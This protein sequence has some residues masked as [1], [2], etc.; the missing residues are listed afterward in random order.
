MKV[1]FRLRRLP[2][3]APA[4]GLLLESADAARLLDLCARLG[5]LWP[6]VY[7]V[8]G[9]F[10]VALAMPTKRR[11]PGVIRLRRLAANLYVPVD[12]ALVPAL[13]R[14]EAEGLVRER[15]LVFLPGA[16]VL[17]FDAHRPVAL[18]SLLSAGTPRRRVWQP[19]PSPRARADRLVDI[20][21]VRADEPDPEQA[22]ESE[23]TKDIGT[24][25]PEPE[26]AGPISTAAGKAQV[27]LGKALMGLGKALGFKG[28]A[29]AGARMMTSAVNRVP[30]LTEGLLGRQ[31][32]ALRE[33]LR[34]FRD[35][36]IERA[37]RR[38]LPLGD[39]GT[40]GAGLFG[41]AQLPFNRLLYSLRDL[42]G[43]GSGGRVGYWL[44]GYD[45]WAELIQE[46][47]KAAEAALNR[48][49]FRRAAYIYGKL[50][51]DFRS[52]ANAL[53]QGGLHHDAALIYL[54]KV[55]DTQAAARAFE[56]AGELDRALALYRERGDHV[57]AGDLL[58]RMGDE[59]AALAEYRAAADQLARGRS[60]YLAAGELVLSKV[61][62]ID[63][64][65]AYFQAG[66]DERP[67]AGAVA[68]ALRMARLH[69]ER[70]AAGDLLTL[71]AEGEQHYAGAG[72]AKEAGQF[73]NALA[74]VADARPLAPYRDEIRDR[75]LCGIARKLRER[76]EV[77][78]RAGT[79]VS[80]LLGS[81][82]IWPAAVVSDAQFAYVRALRR[83]DEPPGE[84]APPREPRR[85]QVGSGRVTAAAVARQ[86]GSVF[87]GFQDGGVY[88]FE[89]AAGEVTELP[90][91]F[92]EKRICLDLSK[93]MAQPKEDTLPPALSL[94]VTPDGILLVALRDDNGF[95]F[96]SSH[97]RFK[98]RWDEAVRIPIAREDPS[99][100]LGV[101]VFDYAVGA[102]RGKFVVL[103]DDRK[104]LFDP[105]T[106]PTW[107]ALA[108][109]SATRLEGGF[110]LRDPGSPTEDSPAALLFDGTV[111]RFSSHRR[112]AGPSVSL[113]WRPEIPEG[114][115]LLAPPF[116]W[117]ARDDLG[118]EIAGLKVNGAL[119]WSLVRLPG[120]SSQAHR[121]EGNLNHL[122]AWMPGQHE[123]MECMASCTAAPEDGYLAAAIVRSGLVA[124]VRKTSIHWLRAGPKS[125]APWALT[126]VAIPSA[127]A[128][129]PCHPTNELVVVCR[130]GGVVRVD[131]PA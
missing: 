64:A 21:V 57:E 99:G 92:E 39:A 98:A 29:A 90:R 89:P 115:S 16:R 52:A 31:E 26:G 127:I 82:A 6:A 47:R 60:Q 43:G 33:L 1:P 84:A 80:A 49:D 11:F 106:G 70:E 75:C 51:K 95:R 20:V 15:G 117:L 62:R 109:D 103:G 32:A 130:D 22:L 118:V 107:P 58:R 19:L 85:T 45:V 105:L 126:R 129:F 13:L 7:S 114:S 119:N 14:D 12:A 77:E 81:A 61:G 44:G 30:K 100:W 72:D 116:S 42:L 122:S 110:V 23:E 66:W 88:C 113:G 4:D 63:L 55:G 8:A 71:L 9:G 123:M 53:A 131:I 74:E 128:C 97:F 41:G 94:A 28:L 46:Y 37:L 87:I 18:S 102:G 35:G 96:M 40:R 73:F 79:T 34:Q 68:C 56:A 54:K 108:V 38:A 91:E 86:T 67:R 124:G 104:V 5:G 69:A 76:A 36:N 10:V 2:H 93:A 111:L 59:E 17:A 121:S 125:F 24:E 3:A 101:D 27:G 25:S 65:L 112:G 50:L 48:G 83:R 78:T 120:V